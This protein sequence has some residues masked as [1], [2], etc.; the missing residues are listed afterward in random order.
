MLH[1]FSHVEG[2]RR[3]K[4]NDL[5]MTNLQQ[6]V[7]A[8]KEVFID[9]PDEPASQT[10]EK[11]P[12]E[13]YKAIHKRTRFAMDAMETYNSANEDDRKLLDIGFALCLPW[14][15]FVASHK[16]LLRSWSK[17]GVFWR[18]GGELVDPNMSGETYAA[19][20]ATAIDAVIFWMTVKHI[21][22]HH[23]RSVRA[24]LQFAQWQ[25]VVIERHLTKSK[26]QFYVRSDA[27]NP[28]V[29]G[30]VSVI[31]QAMWHAVSVDAVK[32]CNAPT[33][34][35]RNLQATGNGCWKKYAETINIQNRSLLN[36]IF[37]KKHRVH[38]VLRLIPAM[39]VL[40][41]VSVAQ[42]STE[43]AADASV[44]DI[45]NLQ[46]SI[47]DC[48]KSGWTHE[49]VLQFQHFYS[50]IPVRNVQ[51]GRH[52]VSDVLDIFQFTETQ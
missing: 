27:H 1:F 9:R 6:F 40:L 17:K 46:T 15:N 19:W 23:R 24:A 50:R 5:P 32:L 18:G 26:S 47:I 37:E 21:Q 39:E 14:E 2:K 30:D 7:N 35:F 38:T 44:D 20:S 49:A 31:P 3:S 13:F 33:S 28:V 48:V 12:T 51:S 25:E 16:S 42:V 45:E 11:L 43:R 34:L 10:D 36:Q 4:D 8:L 29:F 22:K 41:E 52:L